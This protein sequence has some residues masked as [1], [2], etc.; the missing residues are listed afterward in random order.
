MIFDQLYF[1]FQFEIALFD[2]KPHVLN[3]SIAMSF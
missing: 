3:I 1:S 2:I